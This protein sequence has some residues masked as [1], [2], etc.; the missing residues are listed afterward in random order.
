MCWPTD[1]P[2]LV[3]ARLG[4]AGRS[5]V[6][7]DKAYGTLSSTSTFSQPLLPARR[8]RDADQ[9]GRT[10]V[11]RRREGGVAGHG[12]SLRDGAP[13]GAGDGVPAR[14]EASRPRQPS[15]VPPGFAS[16]RRALPRRQHDRSDRHPT[17]PVHAGRRS[18]CGSSRAAQP[19][20]LRRGENRPGEPRLCGTWL[21]TVRLGAAW[22]GW[23]WHGLEGLGRV[24]TGR[25]RIGVSA[26]AAKVASA[27]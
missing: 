26:G 27:D 21:E 3:M 17:R 4:M 20:G 8:P 18:A 25:A 22:H 10:G 6:R 11:P 24:R 23:I 19:D 13:H 14:S 1:G 15:Q 16:A 2:W 7:L 12:R 9:P 5:L